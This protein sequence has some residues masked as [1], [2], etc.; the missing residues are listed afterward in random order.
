MPNGSKDLKNLRYTLLSIFDKEIVS[1]EKLPFGLTNENYK[2]ELLDGEMYVARFPGAGSHFLVDR[3]EEFGAIQKVQQ[4][5][6]DVE[7]VHFDINS[8]L[9]ITRFV[10]STHLSTNDQGYL[11]RA[12]ATLKKLH[13]SGLKF[14]NQFDFASKID[15]YLSVADKLNIK[16]DRDLKRLIQEVTNL[17]QVSPPNTFLVAAHNDLVPENFLYTSTGRIFLI[18]WEY[19]GMN[20]PIW[21]IASFSLEFQLNEVD[22]NRLLNLYF[23]NDY[24]VKSTISTIQVNKI[25]QDLLWFV[26]SLIK[27][28]FGIDLSQYA[29]MRYARAMTNFMKFKSQ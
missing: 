17:S 29:E 6:I 13:E 26:W 2:C 22:E 5:N 15:F 12:V 9:K 11:E 1:I 28:R 20:T 18:D 23:G 8:G 21:D 16:I 27:I 3:K 24:D 10:D 7:T 14:E 25:Y 4:L 19:S